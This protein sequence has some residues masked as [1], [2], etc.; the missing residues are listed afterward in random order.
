MEPSTRPGGSRLRVTS[1]SLATLCWSATSETAA[2]MHLTHRTETSWASSMTNTATRSQ[3]TGFGACSSATASRVE[4][5]T[6]FSSRPALMMRLT[7]YSARCG[8]C[9][10]MKTAATIED[11]GAPSYDLGGTTSRPE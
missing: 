3:S 11:L 7:V 9:R 8:P 4:T 5:P 10:T 2:L 6:Y 1:A